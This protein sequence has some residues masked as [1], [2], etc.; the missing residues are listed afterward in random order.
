MA[1]VA[2]PKSRSAIASVTA[3]GSAIA[4]R[5]AAT[6]DAASGKLLPPAS[7]RCRTFGVSPVRAEGQPSMGSSLF[8]CESSP[9]IL[10]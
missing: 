8:S 9:A 2:T 4:N 6:T 5:S 3:P 7:K 1:T 10:A